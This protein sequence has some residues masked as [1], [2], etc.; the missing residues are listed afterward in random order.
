[1]MIDIRWC[2]HHCIVSEDILSD[3]WRWGPYNRFVSLPS[4][5]IRHLVCFRRR[6]WWIFNQWHWYWSFGNLQF[7]RKKLLWW[8]HLLMLGMK[9]TILKPKVAKYKKKWVTRGAPSK[10][11]TFRLLLLWSEMDT[12]MAT[13][14]VL[15]HFEIVRFFS[16]RLRKPFLSGNS[17]FGIEITRCL[18]NLKIVK[19]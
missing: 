8:L 10:V 4:I 19:Y 14:E 9:R 3:R 11:C 12:S 7:W 5:F 15:L 6:C 17:N 1:M 2:W 18:E 16:R 13:S